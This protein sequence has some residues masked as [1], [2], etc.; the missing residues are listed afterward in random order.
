MSDRAINDLCPPDNS[1]RLAFHTVPSCTLTSS[2]CVMSMPSGGWS[3]EKFPG[4]S[5]AKMLPNSLRGGQL[6]VEEVDKGR[7]H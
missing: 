2:P 6:D 4:N 7:T 1:V 5:S 3:L